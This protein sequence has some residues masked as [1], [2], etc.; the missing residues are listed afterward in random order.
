[1]PELNNQTDSRPLHKTGD[2]FSKKWPGLGIIK[3]LKTKTRN[4]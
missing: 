4:I 2:L 3:P 1:M